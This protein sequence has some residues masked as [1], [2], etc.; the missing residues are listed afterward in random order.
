MLVRFG[1]AQR[2]LGQMDRIAFEFAGAT[3]QEI[4][5]V[6][7]MKLEI[8][9]FVQPLMFFGERKAAELFARV[10]QPEHVSRRP[11]GKLCERRPE[12]DVI[13]NVHGVGADLDASPDFAQAGGL[14][15]YF[16]LMAGLH[17]AGGGGKSA[18]ARSS[19]ENFI[20]HA[21]PR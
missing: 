19:D 10:M 7:A 15:V 17:Q 13:E 14:L 6:G 8:G 3:S 4:V 1:K 11:Y 21:S 12:T 2:L 20:S 18:E 5:Q 16:D 9:R